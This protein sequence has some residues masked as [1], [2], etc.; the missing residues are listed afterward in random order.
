MIS[1]EDLQEFKQIYLEEYGETI[2]DTEALRL[3]T[4]LLNL[5]K[6]IYRTPPTKKLSND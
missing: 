6:V 5:F 1:K 2:S 4:N 3:A